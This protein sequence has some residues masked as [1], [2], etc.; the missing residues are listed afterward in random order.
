MDSEVAVFVC[1]LLY[2]WPMLRRLGG[3]PWPEPRTLRLPALR[4]ITKK[5]GRREY[6][7]G[8]LRQEGGRLVVEKFERDGSGLITSLRMADGLI[9]AVEDV[10]SIGAGELVTFI[11]FTE[12]GIPRL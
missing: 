4:A 6:W 9:E 2:A 1:F 8:M 11:P 10:G 5:T 7:R 12:Y 3:A